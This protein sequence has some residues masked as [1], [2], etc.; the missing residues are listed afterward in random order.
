MM[1]LCF[2]GSVEIPSIALLGLGAKT[3]PAAEGP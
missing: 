2:F 1:Y 3:I